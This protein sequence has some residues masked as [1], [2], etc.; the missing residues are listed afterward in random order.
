[1]GLSPI[2]DDK[3]APVLPEKIQMLHMRGPYA[4]CRCQAKNQGIC[5]ESRNWGKT[6]GVKLMI[7]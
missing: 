1:M 2:S 4:V 5:L 7:G 6:K 3:E